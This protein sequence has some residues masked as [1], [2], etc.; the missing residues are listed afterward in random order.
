[1]ANERIRSAAKEH[2][3]HLWEIAAALNISD[4]TFSRQLRN[5]LP[6]D[7]QNEIISKIEHLTG[8]DRNAEIKAAA[9]ANHVKIWEI[10]ERMNM[11]DS[12]FSRFMRKDLS[13]IERSALLNTINEIALERETVQVI[14]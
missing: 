3:L 6:E 4:N 5:E 11:S 7:R 14:Q 12:D 2:N 1:M 9:A 10:A 13:S 8:T